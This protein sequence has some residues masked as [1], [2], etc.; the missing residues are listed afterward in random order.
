[1]FV[2]PGAWRV[3]APDDGWVIHRNFR[4]GRRRAVDFKRKGEDVDIRVTISPIAEEDRHLPLDVLAD[5]LMLNYGRAR[6]IKTDVETIQR[7]DF[8]AHEGVVVYATRKA[9]LVERRI[10]QAFV[11]A[12][13]R[14][15]MLSY[16][17]P[18]EK[19]ETYAPDFAWA[20]SK[21]VVLLPADRPE[22]GLTLPSDLPDADAAPVHK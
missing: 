17:A 9:S 11:R 22:I 20:V 7:V 12:G 6:G 2:S 14:L 8:G 16:I 18:P 19:Y 4:W 21:F 3:G 15:V 13:D 10:A 1:M 5:A